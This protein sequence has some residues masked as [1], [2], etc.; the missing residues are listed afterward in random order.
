M[1]LRASEP[2]YDHKVMFWV[3]I[4]LLSVPHLLVLAGQ[5]SEQLL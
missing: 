5:Y 3:A 2:T 4:S 1:C